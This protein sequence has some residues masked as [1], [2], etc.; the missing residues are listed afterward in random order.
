MGFYLSPSTHLTAKMATAKVIALAALTSL[1]W[2]TS[3]QAYAWEW[4]G[5]CGVSKSTV[6]TCTFV[7]GDGALRGETGTTYTYILPTGDR[8]MRFVADAESGQIC[9]SPG[10]MRK[11]NGPWFRIET[12]CQGPFIVHSLPTGN[13]MLVEIYDTP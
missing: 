5:K 11:N 9:E 7:K 1:Q 8:F 3:L 13:S 4:K 10:L 12:S 6:S 2:L